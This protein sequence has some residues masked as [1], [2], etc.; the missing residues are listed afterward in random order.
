MP[1]APA[2]DWVLV[3]SFARGATGLSAA[4]LALVVALSAVAAATADRARPLRHNRAHWSCPNAGLEPRPGDLGRIRAAT[5]CLVNRERARHG[6]APLGHSFRLGLAAQ[7][8]SE[9]MARGRYFAHAGPAGDTPLS[10]IRA[11]GYLGRHS[12]YAVGENIAWGTLWLSTPRA[13]VASW[14]ASPEHRAN[15]LDLRF[16]DSAI[17]VAALSLHGRHRLQHGGIYTEDFGALGGQG[18][19]QHTS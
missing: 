9:S 8:H 10:R 16:R 3:R 4:L 7:R 12:S 1:A 17:G 13:I 11:T 18:R 19:S 5:L 6:E 14:M 2:A 15:I